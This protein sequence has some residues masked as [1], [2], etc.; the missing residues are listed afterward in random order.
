MRSLRK[1]L[2]SYT[3]GRM[4]FDC[5]PDT[6]LVQEKTKLWRDTW[7]L[8]VLD[9]LIARGE[10]RGTSDDAWTIQCAAKEGW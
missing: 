5:G 3:D 2:G 4:N 1:K 9:A 6:E 7:I 8:P 10:N